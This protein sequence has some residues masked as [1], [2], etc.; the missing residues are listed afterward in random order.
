MEVQFAKNGPLFPV[1]PALVNVND[2]KSYKPLEETITGG[3]L[4]PALKLPV[5]VLINGMLLTECS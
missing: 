3:R 4:L 5:T 1:A 2:V